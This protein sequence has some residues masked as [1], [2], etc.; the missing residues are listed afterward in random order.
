MTT[1]TCTEQRF[2]DDVKGHK[3]TIL[4]DNGVDR[5]IRFKRP[6]GSCYW[7]DIITY[8]GRLI[9]D[10]DCGTYVFA[11]IEDMFEFFR[12][13]DNDYNKNPNGL[14]INPSYWG[15]KLRSVSNR[16]YGKG[17]IKNFSS[18]KF[19]RKVKEYFDTH[20]EDINWVLYFPF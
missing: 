9:I 14:S 2:L 7:F 6:N 3:L 10:G 18:D 5:H 11:R 12:M 4:R 20:F 1:D 8:P 15:E 16:G 17:A 19:D 13:R